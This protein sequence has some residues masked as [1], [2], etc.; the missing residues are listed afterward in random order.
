MST[1]SLPRSA[2]IWIL[3]LLLGLFS[4]TLTMIGPMVPYLQAETGM[5]FTLAGLHQTVV[6]VGMV[7]MGFVASR[8][9]GRAGLQKSLWFSLAGMILGISVMTLGRG[10]VF[11][12]GGILFMSL[13]ATLMLA[14]I[15]TC[16]SREPAAYR[17]R[18]IMEANVVAS[19]LTMLVP[20]VLLLGRGTV[21]G[22]RIVLPFMAGTALLLG[23]PGQS[24]T[25][26]KLN[27][28]TIA[29]D[30]AS[31]RLSGH[32]WRM[33]LII[34]L[35]VTVEWAIGFWCM[36]YLLSLAGSTLE[37]A[38]M[39]TVVLGLSAVAGRL[40]S[41]RLGHRFSDKQ[42]I[43][44][45]LL[46]VGIGF[47]L[48][49][50]Q[51]SLTLTFAGLILCGFGAATF[52]PLGLALAL[53]AAPGNGTKASSL[54]PVASGAAI[55]MAPF[56]LGRLADLTSMKLALLYIPLGLLAILAVLLMDAV[57]G[58]RKT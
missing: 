17:G 36:T 24:I 1:N 20:L 34:F 30:S 28:M 53:N 49:W 29:A 15:Q 11:S 8:F 40:V 44:A 4:F 2:Y 57:L 9:I 42:M 27:S 54:A 55:G 50:A 35:G 39:G 16:F 52:Y 23:I 21:L 47:P 32:F 5:S 3:Y 22:W 18:Y 58:K 10:L 25:G 13:C 45:V 6:A 19:I 51:A 38:A 46:I 56:L 33:W 14:A 48:Y 37:T 43:F 7:L 41:S 31:G 26:K 12:M